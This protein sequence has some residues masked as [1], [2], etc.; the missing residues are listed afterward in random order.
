MAQDMT[1]KGPFVK[2]KDG[3][4]TDAGLFNHVFDG[5]DDAHDEV[6]KMKRVQK[7]LRREMKKRGILK[8]SFNETLKSLTENM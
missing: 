6:I 5:T 4:P 1:G 8:E 2:G 3:Q 7:V